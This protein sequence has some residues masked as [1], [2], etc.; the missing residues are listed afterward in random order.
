MDTL[1]PDRQSW[2]VGDTLWMYPSSNASGIGFATLS[3]FVPGRA[4]ALGTLTRRVWR[5]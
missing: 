3:E 5:A 2:A 4:L 1:R